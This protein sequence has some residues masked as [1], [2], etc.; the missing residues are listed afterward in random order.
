MDRRRARAIAAEFIASSR[1]STTRCAEYLGDCPAPSS[2]LAGSVQQAV[3]RPKPLVSDAI[4]VVEDALH[5]V[6]PKQHENMYW[7]RDIQ[8]CGQPGAG[9]HPGLR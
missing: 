8:N 3:R 5:P 6:Q 1:R 4:A 2:V 9:T 7:M